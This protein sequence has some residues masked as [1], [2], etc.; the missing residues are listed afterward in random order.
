M[1]AVAD[2]VVAVQ[3]SGPLTNPET[4]DVNVFEIALLH[5]HL[6]LPAVDLTNKINFR[7]ESQPSL[8]FLLQLRGGHYSLLQL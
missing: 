1:G 5:M 2:V 3:S 4:N 7:L 8:G 6:D